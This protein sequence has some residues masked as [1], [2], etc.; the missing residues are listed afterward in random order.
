[1][2]YSL[3]QHGH[4]TFFQT[5]FQQSPNYILEKIYFKSFTKASYITNVKTKFGLHTNKTT[6]TTIHREYLV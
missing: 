6:V 1:M 4:T 2:S 5:D 3:T